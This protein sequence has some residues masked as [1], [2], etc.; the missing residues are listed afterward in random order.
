MDKD[1][2]ILKYSKTDQTLMDKQKFFGFYA[3][4]FVILVVIVG[5]MGF[6]MGGFLG[7]TLGLPVSKT[8]LI[9][10]GLAIDI[11]LGNFF[12]K[13]RET[14]PPN[15]VRH[16]AFTKIGKIKP[17]WGMSIVG[18]TKRMNHYESIERVRKYSD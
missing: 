13:N 4:E 7:D 10:L 15:F 14:S 17:Q 6:S 2:P 9:L 16:V 12:L 3:D 18:D 8:N 5:F 11:F 1:E